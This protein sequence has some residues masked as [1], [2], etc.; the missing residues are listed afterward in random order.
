MLRQR[1]EVLFYLSQQGSS[2]VAASLKTEAGPSSRRLEV[3]PEDG[4]TSNSPE[5]HLVWSE[6]S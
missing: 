1:A 3:A 4:V 2:L 5:S 6:L